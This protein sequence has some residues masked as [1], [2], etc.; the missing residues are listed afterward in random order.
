MR[1]ILPAL[2][3]L[4]CYVTATHAQ[5]PATWTLSAKPLVEI[6]TVEG[7]PN[8]ELFDARSSVRL[9][10]GRIAILN[11]GS[12]ELRFFDAKGK[13]LF[14]T[15]TK[16]NGPGEY[17]WPA[18]LYYTQRD[19]LIIYDQLN[20]RE[21]HLDTQGRFSSGA[22]GAPV[23]QDRFKRDAWLYG[24]TFVDGPAIAAERNRIKPGLNQ[25]PPLTTTTEYRYVKVDPWYRLWVRE[26]R[27]AGLPLQ[28]WTIFSADGQRLATLDTPATFEIHQIG[29]DFLLGN[30]RDELDVEHIRLYALETPGTRPSREYFTPATARAYTPPPTQP[31]MDR[32]AWVAM[33]GYV[34]Q[35][36]GQQEIYYSKNS[37]YAADLSSLH[38]PD[39]K[40]ITPHI[41]FASNRGWGVLVIHR[42][43]DAL[44]AMAM[45]AVPIGWSQ[46]MAICGE[47]AGQQPIH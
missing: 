41:L 27:A 20:D 11:A 3:S 35:L 15:G 38:P 24:R 40:D 1:R 22:D 36:A 26:P 7:D 37:T 29:P 43:A 4:L 42:G 23:K 16:G 46:G 25:L 45:G 30:Q 39:Q 21:S 6:G 33:T 31:A 8:H 9:L 44:C 19:S 12:R 14:R 32:A 13:F 2:P 34:R 5:A 28:R 47:V 18:R 10:D 17:L